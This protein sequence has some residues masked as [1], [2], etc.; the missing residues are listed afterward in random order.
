RSGPTDRYPMNSWTHRALPLLA[1]LLLATPGTAQPPK[2]LDHLTA[3]F[4][5]QKL[6]GEPANLD[7]IADRTH[8]VT[9][10][11]GSAKTASRALEPTQLISKYEAADPEALY[12]I[13]FQTLMTYELNQARFSVQ[14]FE[15]GRVLVLDPFGRGS[16][17]PMPANFAG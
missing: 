1:A 17:H 15:P 6:A 4:G 5:Y 13:S 12:V 9:Q 16:A 8:R 7:A 11:K 2:A 14:T 10:A 3:Y